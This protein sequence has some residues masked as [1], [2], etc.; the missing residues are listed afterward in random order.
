MTTKQKLEIALELDGYTNF[1][2]KGQRWTCNNEED[3]LDDWIVAVNGDNEEDL[4][5]YEDI[6]TVE[7]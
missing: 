7:D 4:V 5:L 1:T 2:A 3:L 6:E